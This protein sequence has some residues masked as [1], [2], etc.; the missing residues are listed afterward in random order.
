MGVVM[1]TRQFENF[2]VCRDVARR[3]GSLV[4]LLV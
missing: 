4:K 3:A 1:V 2:A